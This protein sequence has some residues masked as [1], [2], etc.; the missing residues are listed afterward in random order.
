[1]SAAIALPPPP[2]SRPLST[3]LSEP[4]WCCS[5]RR[6]TSFTNG[7]NT[8]SR[9]RP[10]EVFVQ[11]IESSFPVDRVRADEPFDLGAVTDPQFGGVELAH[12]RKFVAHGFVRRDAVEMAALDHEGP[13]RD[14]GR[15]LR[16]VE[17]AAQIELEDFI[18]PAPNVAVRAARRG[19]L[20]DPLVEIRRADRKTIVRHQWRN[21][22]RRLAAVTQAVKA[23]ALRVNEEQR[24]QP[25]DNLLVLRNDRGEQRLL[26]RIALA[27]ER[28][29]AVGE[30]VKILRRER[31]EPA[32]RQFR[33]RIFTFSPTASA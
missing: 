3:R 22:H 24:R 4:C 17:G 13:R 2:E 29:E 10:V 6:S 18:F 33:R 11:K 20:P 26:Q 14:Q 21:A 16:V 25:I 7:G 28:A 31:D 12:L 15:H 19:V 5:A 27:L 8:G 32:L 30:K 23:D 9:L 1:M